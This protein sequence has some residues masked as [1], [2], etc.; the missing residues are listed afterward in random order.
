M[1]SAHTP[2][3]ATAPTPL[4]CAAM[5]KKV[6]SL[7]LGLGLSLVAFNTDCFAQEF[8]PAPGDW[9]VTLGG[10]G[11]NDKDFDNGGFA[12]DGSI[13]YYINR[14]LEISVRQGIAY[15]DTEF[16]DSTW[17]GVTR[18][19]LDYHF[20][21]ARLRPY[22]GVTFGGVY[23]DNRQ[24]SWM[25]GLGTGLKFYVLEKTFLFVAGEYNWLFRD[26]DRADDNFDDG[27]FNYSV[28][29]GFNF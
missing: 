9:E 21:L 24:D 22:I 5:T 26:A 14:N 8:G 15:S 27:Q 13:G 18:G 25:A 1:P 4:G 12:L 16:G 7:T 11:S 3:C 28:G 29:I 6:C 17:G 20:D 2:H 23:G 10:G 19:A